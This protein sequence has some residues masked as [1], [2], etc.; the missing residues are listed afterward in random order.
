MTQTT[1]VPFVAICPSRDR[2]YWLEQRKSGIG[3]SEVA[4]LI[5]A[6]RWASP[7][8]LYADKIGAAE[9][10]EIDPEWI[11]WGNRLEPAII[12]AFGARTGREVEPFGMLLRSTEHPVALAT[13]DSWCIGDRGERWPLEIKT[14][15]AHL[16]EDWSDG[17]PA[18]YVA[19]L[20]WQ[21]LVTGCRRASIACLIGGQR[22]VWSDVDREEWMIGRMLAAAEVFWGY[23]TRREPPPVDGTEASREALRSIYPEESGAEVQLDGDLITIA[24]LLES[25]K[26][27]LRKLECDQLAAENRI[28]A[29][30]GDAAR[31][32]LPDGR[33]FTWVTQSRKEHTVKASKSRVFRAHKAKED[34]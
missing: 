26:I 20:Q 13:L 2:T 33:F 3:A 25:V 8:S 7:L 9:E 16:A 19:Q 17:P 18:A 34:R 5:G 1:D 6:S 30:M 10:R 11:E 27:E 21:M 23:V 28:K 22:L 4:A 12:E 15:G 32:S 31:A 14:T 24:D 29:A